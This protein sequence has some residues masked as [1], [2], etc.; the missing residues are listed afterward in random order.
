MLQSTK[1]DKTYD[2]AIAGAGLAGL[3]SATRLRQ[4]YPA[5]KIL[6][7]EKEAHLGGRLRTPDAGLN[8]G[9]G[10]LHY[11]S[12]DLLEFLNRTL[13]GCARGE[14]DLSL[15]QRASQKIGILQGKKLDEVPLSEFWSAAVAKILGGASAAKQWET[16]CAALAAASDEDLFQ[17]LG[18]VTKITKKDPFLDVL[19]LMS[20]PLGIVGP[21]FATTTS[22]QQR[23]HYL[24]KGLFGGPWGKVIDDIVRWNDLEIL[25]DTPILEA[26]FAARK[27][28]LNLQN[29]QIS[30]TALLVAQ[31]PWEAM[32]WLRREC[33]PAGFIHLA[34]KFSPL[35]AVSL[36]VRLP[37]ALAAPDRILLPSEKTQILQLSPTEFC[38]QAIIDYETFLDAP[39][40]VEA[41]QAFEA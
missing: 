8:L 6:L 17:P 23:V 40:V 21:W 3:L 9:T 12:Q 27:W 25:T 32:P 24:A 38:M 5:A 29:E 11:I 31:S 4:I 36:T 28:V 15:P 14:D 13:L 19:N 35:S 30:S 33:C 26:Q 39:R 10:G 7:I 34:L 18:R 1:I 2:I 16:F 41:G 20:L 37:E 22:F